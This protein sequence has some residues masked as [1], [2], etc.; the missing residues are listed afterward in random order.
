MALPQPPRPEPLR[1]PRPPGPGQNRVLDRMAA[2]GFLSPDKAR[3]A[4]YQPLGVAPGTR[5]L[6]RPILWNTSAPDC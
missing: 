5:P 6:P 4:R 3:R 1:S 2:M